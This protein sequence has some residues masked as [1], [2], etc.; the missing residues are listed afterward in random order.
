MSFQKLKYCLIS[1]SLVQDE[2]YKI[3]GNIIR[4]DPFPGLFYERSDPVVLTVGSG[5]CFLERQI[6]VSSIR[7][8]NP[9]ANT[10][11]TTTNSVKL[12]LCSATDFSHM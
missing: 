5:Y 8:I 1:R 4:S 11:D 3:M 2:A 10:F 12:N 7:I 9:A 6:R